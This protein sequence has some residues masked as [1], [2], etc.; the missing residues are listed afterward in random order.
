MPV[1]YSEGSQHFKDLGERGRLR[2]LPVGKDLPRSSELHF[3]RMA[4]PG[5][6]LWV[7][8]LGTSEREGK[9]AGSVVFLNCSEHEQSSCT[10]LWLRVPANQG[11]AEQT[12]VD[13]IKTLFESPLERI[14]SSQSG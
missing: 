3:Q 11:W 5:L 13:H 2:I 6:T 10:V 12:G 1:A 4:S 9:R 7:A 14:E 8:A